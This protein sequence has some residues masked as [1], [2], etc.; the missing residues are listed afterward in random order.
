MTFK[1]MMSLIAM[2]FLWTGSQIPVY[3][4]GGIPPLIYG[5]IGGTDR[6]TWFVL[7]NLLAL[8]A[9]CPFVG[10]LSDLMGRRYVAIMGAVLIIVGVTIASTAHTMNIFI[11]KYSTVNLCMRDHLLTIVA[12][13]AIAGAGAGINELTAL[14]VTS[15]LAPTRK[16]GKYVAILVFTI[17]PFCPSVLWAQLIAAHGGWRYCGVLC[18][19]WAAVGLIM[20][21]I[22]YF[23]PPRVNSKGLTKMEIIKQIDFVGGFLSITGML[24]FMAGLQWGGYQVCLTFVDD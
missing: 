8:A 4:F 7:A 15:E 13:M 2:A 16:R 3:I 22:F 11:G 18:G 1:R 9:V 10:S 23:P 14:A 5:D 21:I 12:G 19:V 17:V 20:T 6:W 24:V